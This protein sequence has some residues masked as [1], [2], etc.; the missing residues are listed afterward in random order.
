M[1]DSWFSPNAI[2]FKNAQIVFLLKYLSVIREGDW[3]SADGSILNN[4]DY[5]LLKDTSIAKITGGGMGS[6][7]PASDYTLRKM[8][9]Q[10]KVLEIAREMDAR[11]KACG[12]GELLIARYT[13]RVE[14]RELCRLFGLGRQEVYYRCQLAIKYLSGRKRKR[15]DYKSYL[16]NKGVRT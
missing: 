13:N 14:I 2:E 11:L 7:P 12:D 6:S 1:E 10:G 5:S 4:G 9:Y 16:R 15:T 8:Y 3:I